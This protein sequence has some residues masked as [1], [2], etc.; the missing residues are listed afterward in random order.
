[1]CKEK[2]K[3]F[4][5]LS[6]NDLYR[7]LPGYNAV[8]YNSGHENVDKERDTKD[9]AGAF[10]KADQRDEDSLAE[11]RPSDAEVLDVEGS[12]DSCEDIAREKADPVAVLQYRK[13]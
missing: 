5:S 9:K 3:T 12:K 6:S 8:R 2:Y 4:N 1:M 7:R 10:K 13:N 11:S